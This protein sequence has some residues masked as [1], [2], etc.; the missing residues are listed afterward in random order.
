MS[1]L[2][3]PA[4]WGKFHL[5][6]KLNWLKLKPKHLGDIV[7]VNT[8]PHSL[9]RI[10][11]ILCIKAHSHVIVIFAFAWCERTLNMKKDWY[12]LDKHLLKYW[13]LNSAF[14][15]PSQY[16][17]IFSI[18]LGYYPTHD[19]F[20]HHRYI[21]LEYQNPSDAAEAVAATN[22]YKLDK[23]HTFIVNLFSDFEKWVNC[24]L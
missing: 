11:L 8:A 5:F 19:C 22:G 23:S 10:N 17:Y 13:K 16:W 14:S 12:N 18:A 9:W 6:M 20:D 2:P 1:V 4:P 21:F 7:L 3:V 24:V 15:I